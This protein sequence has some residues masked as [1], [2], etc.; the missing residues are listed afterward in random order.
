M[1]SQ[2]Q[3][4]EEF[5]S[6]ITRH[7]QQR[8]Q[9]WE[10][11]RRL[12]EVSQL[13]I[14]LQRLI[15][16]VRASN[17]SPALQDSLLVALNH[18]KAQRIQD[19]SGPSLRTITGLPPSKALRALCVYFDL[20][21]LRTSRWQVPSI[22]SETVSAFLRD[23]PTPFELLLTSN[24]P[25]LLDL[26]AGDLSFAAELADLYAP[27]IQQHNRTLIL[28]CIDRL[29]PQS[30]L[31]GPLHPSPALV[32]RLRSRPDLS[33][34]F[35]PDQDMC[36]F[37]SLAR[38]GRLATR[39]TISTCWAPA[40]PTF[41]YEP[42]RLSPEVIEEELNRSRGR[43]ATSDMARNPPSKYSIVTTRCSFRLG[44]LRYAARWLSWTCWRVPVTWACWAPLTVRCSGKCWHSFSKGSDT[45]RKMSRSHPTT[46]PPF[47]VMSTNDFRP[48]RSEKCWISRRARRCAPTFLMPCPPRACETATGF[49][50]S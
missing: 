40:T 9:E 25:S 11:S 47:L 5:R 33:F 28:H 16:R 43:S 7:L 2:D 10:R 26:G 34:Q 45:G 44:S 27:K 46:C 22:D 12:L 32:Q 37:E 29:H 42:T 4:L 36:E 1:T 30:K 31:G 50:R 41:A 21:E 15:E 39:Y 18:G 3:F 19:L 13:A 14:T 38:N 23:H 35:L 48:S 8:D 17:L 24:V 49:V 6:Q 20:V